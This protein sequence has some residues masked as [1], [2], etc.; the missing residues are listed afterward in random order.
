M[1]RHGV[2]IGAP[3]RANTNRSVSK[4][5]SVHGVQH[6]VS[7]AA[8]LIRSNKARSLG[9]HPGVSSLDLATV[10]FFQLQ[11]QTS[12]L[13]NKNQHPHADTRHTRKALPSRNEG[14]QLWT[15]WSFLLFFLNLQAVEAW[16]NARTLMLCETPRP[17]ALIT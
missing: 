8:G 7:A 10:Y 14:P 12:S 4:S 1:D 6:G 5:H 9:N 11:L 15:G 17:S 16:P 13:T 3:K 2:D